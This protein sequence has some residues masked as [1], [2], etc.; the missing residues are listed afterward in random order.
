MLTEP[1]G[2]T[3]ARLSDAL[4]P[5]LEAVFVG[6]N[7]GKRSAEIGHHFA[8]ANNLFWRLL[9]DAGLTPRLLSAADDRTLPRYGFGVTN[10]V[11]RPS[12]RAADLSPAEYAAGALSLRAK[13]EC[14]RP[15]V[16]CCLGKDVYRHYARLPRG[17]AVPWGRQAGEVVPG[18]VDFLAPNPSARS[19][20]PYA[21]RLAIFRDLSRTIRSL[22]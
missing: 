7:P 19:T 11:D 5:G 18:V 3:A 14:F 17:T 22:A 8:G 21:D 6:I 16:L 13:V 9:F 2:W 4:T 12:H 15:R 10:I 1:E 20:I